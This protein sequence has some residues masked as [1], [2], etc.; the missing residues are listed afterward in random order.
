MKKFLIASFFILLMQPSI[1]VAASGLA[2]FIRHDISFKYNKSQENITCVQDAKDEKQW[3]YVSNRPRLAESKSGEPM[4]KLVSF[5]KNSKAGIKNDGGIFQCGISLTLPDDALLLAKKE[6]SKTAGLQDNKIKLAPLDMK[7]AKIMVYDLLGELLGNNITYPEIGPSFTNE[8]IPI[9]MSLNNLG[10]PVT[11]ALL[12]GNGGLQVYYVFNYNCLTPKYSA[13]IAASYDKAFDYF[14]HNR[15]SYESAK[16]MWLIGDSADVNV[17]DLRESLTQSGVLMI[18]TIGGDELTDEQLNKISEPVIAKLMEGLYSIETPSKVEPDKAYDLNYTPSYWYNLT[19]SVAIKDE[20][21]RNTGEFVYDFRKQYVETR[22]TTIGGLLSLNNY[23]EAQRKDAIQTVDPTYWK[24]AFYSLPTISKSLNRVDEMT[25]S[26]SFLYKG[27]QAEGTESQL[28]K[29]TK[30]NG[31]LNAKNEECIGLEFPL[32]YLYDKYSD[33]SRHFADDVTFQQKFAVT[34]ME[35]NDTKVKEFTTIVPAFSSGIPISTP[36][37]GITYIEF[38]A[39]SNY[40]TWDKSIYEGSEYRGIKSSLTKISI[41]VESKNP[42][43]RGSGV[44]TSRNPTVGVWFNNFFDKKTGKYEIPQVSATYTFFSDKLA[45]AMNTKDKRTIVIEK[46]DAL[47]E[48]TSITFMDDDYM[49][50]E[51]PDSYK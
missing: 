13:R 17:S 37:V 8:C 34:Y 4:I 16:K 10:V 14:S 51:K 44:L 24:S 39:D 29:W 19:K 47:S 2:S 36:M 28:A 3:Y 7:N 11:E 27:K 6:L 18:E 15:K 48:G 1:L 38:E 32:Q 40:L 30:K 49:P 12:N 26:V 41:K 31:W 45:K 9:Q 20:K 33:K 50:I 43:N 25:V 46:E 23:S 5:Q 42:S 22:K 35:G 21:D